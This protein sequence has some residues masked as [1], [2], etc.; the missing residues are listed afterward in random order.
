MKCFR[1]ELGLSTYAEKRIMKLHTSVSRPTPICH[2]KGWGIGHHNKI[3]AANLAISISLQ[4][5]KQDKQEGRA[6]LQ[7][8]H[9]IPV[10]NKDT[11]VV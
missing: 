7:I 4:T 1:N 6:M 5:W 11:K 9:S 10:P 2:L 8:Y 3:N